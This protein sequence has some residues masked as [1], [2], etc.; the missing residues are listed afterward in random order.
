MLTGVYGGG[1]VLTGTLRPCTKNNSPTEGV[2][3]SRREVLCR[4]GRRS[5]RFQTS[6][7]QQGTCVQG[8]GGGGDGGG[9]R[10]V[11]FFPGV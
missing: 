6:M 2:V 9:E 10:E 7:D 3:Q 4:S 1:A 8:G 11:G 5:S